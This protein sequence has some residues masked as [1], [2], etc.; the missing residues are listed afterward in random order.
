MPAKDRFRVDQVAVSTLAFPR[1]SL[2]HDHLT[3]EEDIYDAP[4]GWG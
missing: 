4:R 1:A 3:G 2:T